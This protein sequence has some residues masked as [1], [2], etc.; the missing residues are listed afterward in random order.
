MA[1][2]R[3]II[4][5]A[6]IT[7]A[8]HTPSMSPYLPATPDQIIKNAVDAARAGAAVVHVHARDEKGKPTADHKTFAYILSAI[9]DQ[10]DVVIGITTGGGQGMTTEERFAVIERFQPEMASANGGTMNF[11]FKGLGDGIKEFLHDWEKPYLDY[12]WDSVFKNTCKD[13]EHYLTVMNACGTLPEFEIFDYGQLNNIAFFVR[14]GLVKKTIYLQFVPGVLGGMPM[15]NEG[16][17][18]ILDQAR[19]IFGPDVQFCTVAG[20]RRMFRSAVFCALNGGNVRVGLEDGLYL[21]PDGELAPDN[22]AQVTKIAG[23]L[24]SL[25]YETA[26]P[27]EAREYLKLKGKDNVKF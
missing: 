7:G 9:K 14:N 5:S 2:Q 3:K 20:G 6:A 11:C 8:I 26:S 21:R 16:F 18:F 22:A 25:D 27:A 17:M 13:I 1:Q 10:C 12:T 15:G 24:K 4:V 19:K 23:I